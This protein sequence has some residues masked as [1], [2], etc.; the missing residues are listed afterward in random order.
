[1]RALRSA[2]I[3]SPQ[4]C[5]LVP[6]PAMHLVTIISYPLSRP[7]RL[8]PSDPL[9]KVVVTRS[10]ARTNPSTKPKLGRRFAR[11]PKP[12]TT[13]A[14][15]MSM[16]EAS[17]SGARATSHFGAAEAA[18]PGKGDAQESQPNSEDQQP[19]TPD[20]LTDAESP[21]TSSR[22]RQAIRPD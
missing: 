19:R 20:E 18:D 17:A 15:P 16:T 6:P 12:T 21:L 10:M 1:M 4:V 5:I 22:A 7:C 9:R 14:L 13:G 11:E 2:S 3:R 8:P